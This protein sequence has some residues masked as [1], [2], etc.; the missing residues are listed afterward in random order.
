[1]TLMYKH[2]QGEKQLNTPYRYLFAITG[3]HTGSRKC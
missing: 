2:H 1:M 3:H